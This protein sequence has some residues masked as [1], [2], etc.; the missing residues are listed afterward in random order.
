MS[1][2]Q[3]R[4]RSTD[5]LAHVVMIA[6]AAALG[7]FL[8]GYDTSVINGAVQAIQDN[9]AVGAALTGVT[10]AAA[11]LGSAVGAAIAGGIA[12]RLGRTRVMQVAAVLFII[13]AIGSALPFTVWDLAWWRIV[14]GVAVGIASMIGPAYIAEVAPAEYRGRLGSL[15][16]LAIVLGIA[17]SQLVNYALASAAGGSASAQLGPLDTWQWMLAVE[18]VPALIYLILAT[19]IPESPRYLV[20]AGKTE[21]ARKVL[22]RIESA[23][24]DE[25]IKEIREALGGEKKPRLSDLRG[26]AGLLPIVWVGMAIAAL[27]QF[28]G[29]NVIFY[30]SS[31]LW[32]SV[33]VEESN[34]LLLSL[35]TS[36][37]NIIGT[38]VAIMLVD[39]IGR[40]PLLVMGSIGMTIALALTGWAFS[41][42][43]VSGD[44]ANLPFAWGVVALLSASAFVFCFAASWGVV[45]WVLLGEMFPPRIR[46]AALALG[47]ATNWVANWLVTV[48]FPTMNAWNLPATYFIYAA[49]ALISLFFVLRYL[50]ETKGRS[51]EEMGS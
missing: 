44:Q 11:L 41:Y 33:G 12:D 9:F 4:G 29:I 36:I 40:K 48:T 24:A 2:D 46:A 21:L 39:K 19:I 35:F 38:I 6:G 20:S 32:Q 50:K 14:G 45:M 3:T 8:F 22:H 42:A 7:G 1:V 26:R 49:F 25:K 16:Q 10:V 18:A 51:L 23:D 17:V 37:V 5:H 47:T 15:Q 30:Y 31:S 28:V 34:S 13:S 43:E 27:Q